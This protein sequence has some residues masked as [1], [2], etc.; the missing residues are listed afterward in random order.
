M[1]FELH[2][3]VN[4]LDNGYRVDLCSWDWKRKFVSRLTAGGISAQVQ[5]DRGWQPS[6]L[7]VASGSSYDFTT[8]GDWKLEPDGPELTAAGDDKG[9]GKLVGIV[10][11]PD[12]TLGDE[13]ELG[14]K[15]TFTAPADGNLFL[16]CRDK[17]NE[18]AD[19]SGRITLRLYNPGTKPGP[20]TDTEEK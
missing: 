10:F 5:A 2:F 18:L 8:S 7:T 11:K 3:F 1:E 6:G 13:F 16:R 9:R 17:W 15:G 4:H 20:Q 14:D 19:N 12:Y